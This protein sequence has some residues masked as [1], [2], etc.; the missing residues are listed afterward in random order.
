MKSSLIVKNTRLLPS[1]FLPPEPP[2]GRGSEGEG[3]KSYFFP[4]RFGEAFFNEGDER[5]LSIF[6]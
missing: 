3:V 1:T 4:P 6:L 2:L 5:D